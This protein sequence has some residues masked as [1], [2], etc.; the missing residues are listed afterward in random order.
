MRRSVLNVIKVLMRF[1]DVNL[2]VVYVYVCILDKT[3]DGTFV[4]GLHIEVK[5]N[6]T[7]CISVAV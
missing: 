4:V 2:V 1:L 3:D 6:I 5:R 7:N